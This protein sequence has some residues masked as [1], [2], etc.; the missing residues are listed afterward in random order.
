MFGILAACS[1]HPASAPVDASG[2]GGGGGGDAGGDA[3]SDLSPPMDGATGSST[4]I[5]V[6]LANEPTAT[7]T[8]SFIAAYQ[9]GSAAWQAAPAA[10]GDHYTFNVSS[11]MWGF[12]WTCVTAAAATRQVNVYYFTVA[13][14]TSLTI[15]I[16]DECSDQAPT[17]VA[18]DGTIANPPIAGNLS[19]GFATTAVD[20]MTGV[21]STYSMQV[22]PAAHDLIVGHAAT[23]LSGGTVID[24]AA[25][26]RGL[27][28]SGATTT[29]DVDFG[30]A[31][32][33]QTAT[34][35]VS[36]T[37]GETATVSTTLFS[38]GGT[39]FTMV[40]ETTG[41]TFT[42][43]GLAG[44]L[45]QA[46]D[47]YDQQIQVS[48]STASAIVEDWTASVANQTYTAPTAL[49]DATSTVPATAPYPRIETT[50]TDYADAIGYDWS[51]TQAL[52]G[53]AC[54]TGGGSCSVVWTMA[55]SPGFVGASPSAEM[56]DLSMV[57]GWD[58]ALQMKTGTSVSGSLRAATSSIG[59]SDFPVQDPAPAGTRRTLVSTTWTATP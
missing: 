43:T 30:S 8:F 47:V 33:T 2:G 40:N 26:Q 39:S 11:P 44:A 9:D 14:T 24:Q 50:W 45:A 59:A 52:S 48:S 17:A 28:V 21:T 41:A 3:G 22:V 51:A 19:V 36:T 15:R 42:S 1:S 35:S 46:G 49:G 58:P 31:Q 16:P 23:S 18:L 27:A 12:A 54:G 7:S 34:V 6:T 32:S 20:A 37:A 29:A 4:P 13:E 25:V 5:T 38:A 53:S 10:T 57:T 55:L 56:P